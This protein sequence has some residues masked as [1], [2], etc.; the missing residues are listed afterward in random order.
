MKK[1]LTLAFA[2]TLLV[3]G[4]PYL[5]A[6]EG[7]A[8]DKPMEHSGMM[9]EGGDESMQGGMHDDAKMQQ[10]HEQMMARHQKMLEH[11]EQQKARLDQLVDEMASA[12]GEAKV[13]AVA[14][15]VQELVAQ[16]QK[17]MG[18]RMEMMEQMGE[19]GMMMH[20][21]AGKHHGG[22][23]KGHAG[24][25]H[26]KGEHGHHGHHAMKGECPHGGDCPKHHGKD[27][28]MGED[29]PMHETMHGESDDEGQ[30]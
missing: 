19:G 16:H 17:Q 28:P 13:D 14:A 20:G 9:A 3:V 10:M 15:V 26:C 29:C 24:C 1:T 27:C 7:Q 23:M 22:K 25:S 11:M 8:D 18:R 5:L 21:K 12:E 4:V 2:L 30:K 6:G